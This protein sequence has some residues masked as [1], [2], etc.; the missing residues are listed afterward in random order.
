MIVVCGAARAPETHHMSTQSPGVPLQGSS[1]AREGV[2]GTAAGVSGEFGAFL[3]RR[4]SLAFEAS[5]PGRFDSVQFTG[6][7]NSRVEGQRRDLV[8][9]GLFHVH[10]PPIGPVR[11]AAIAGPSVI[12]QQTRLRQAFAPFGSNDFGPLG[13]ES[14][15]TE[16]RM[17]F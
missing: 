17:G 1:Q 13:P 10:A 4:L 8:L 16:W 3:T 9:S 7:P 5:V 12:A 6:I 15:A 14:S 11:L 2:G